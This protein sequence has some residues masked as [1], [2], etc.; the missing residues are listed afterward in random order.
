MVFFFMCE[1]AHSQAYVLFF[2]SSVY[3]VSCF[4]FACHTHTFHILYF[5]IYMLSCRLQTPSTG[6]PDP[7]QQRRHL[8]NCYRPQQR[9]A[10][11][12]DSC[13]RQP[14]G[15]MPPPPNLEFWTPLHTFLHLSPIFILPL[16]HFKQLCILRERIHISSPPPT[17]D[18]P[19]GC[20][21]KANL[22]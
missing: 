22:L 17:A 12:N 4:I 5:N 8:C 7:T 2:P 21:T 19:P 10:D 3:D 11:R 14:R 15:V 18:T 9:H 13:I 16:F 20:S 1:T 6:S